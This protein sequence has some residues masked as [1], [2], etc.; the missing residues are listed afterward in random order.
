MTLQRYQG[1]GILR[2]LRYSLGTLGTLE[3]GRPRKTL[4]PPCTSSV[5]WL[6]PS[7]VHQPR[8]GASA[9]ACHPERYGCNSRV[10]FCET[11]PSKCPM[12]LRRAED[13]PGPG[14]I[15]PHLLRFYL[16]SFELQGSAL[17]R[18]VSETSWDA[19]FILHELV[20]YKLFDLGAFPNGEERPK[21]KAPWCWSY[22]L[23]EVPRCVSSLGLG[24]RRQFRSS[25]RM[26]SGLVHGKLPWLGMIR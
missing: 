14:I 22:L 12:R 19:C 17:V 24:A 3:P 11:S 7:Y 5:P 1:C 16:D 21:V 4:E 10:K 25:Q 2:P 26:G 15:L 13:R 23:A 18:F 9:H 8:L 6:C 20:V